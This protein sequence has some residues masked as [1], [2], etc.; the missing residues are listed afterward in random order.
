MYSPARSAAA[1]TS[2]PFSRDDRLAVDGDRHRVRV[3]RRRS[4][5][6]CGVGHATSVVRERE[7]QRAIGGRLRAWT[8]NGHGPLSRQRRYRDQRA[9]STV[10]D[11]RREVL[12][13]Q[14]HRRVD[15][16][17][18]RRADEADRRH[19]VRERHGLETEPLARRVRHVRRGR[20][21]DR[22]RRIV[23]RSASV[24]SPATI[25]STMRY[26]QVPPSRHGTHLPHD[27]WA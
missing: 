19:L 26:S 9:T 20:S 1:M 15:R 4:S 8:R 16:D 17:V 27:S 7:R 18:R 25:R 6:R 5:R 12:G 2:S 10:R 22:P 14:R 21:T 3:D 23:S 24:P 11:A 13:E